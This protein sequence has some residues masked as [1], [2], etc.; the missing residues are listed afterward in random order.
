MYDIVIIGASFAGLTLAHH[1]PENLKVLI[2]EKKSRFDSGVEST[3]LITEATRQQFL[4]FCPIDNFIPNKIDTIGVV[5]PDYDKYFFSSTKKPWIY[6]TDTPKLLEH[7]ARTVPSNVTVE[8]NCQFKSSSIN[9][10]EPFTVNVKYTNSKEEKTCVARFLVGADGAR[11]TV[12]KANPALSQNKKFLAGLEKVFYGEI[13]FG[14]KPKSTVYHF[15]FGDFSLGYGGWL[16]P[17]IINGQA[18]FRV[19]LAK[20]DKDTKDLSRLN[21]FIKILVDKKIIAIKEPALSLYTFGSFIP[22]SGALKNLTADHTLLIGDAA[23][24][25]GAFAADGI[26]GAVISGKIAAELI[27]RYLNGETSA[28]EELKPRLEKDYKLLTYYRKQQFYRWL[29]NQMKRNRTYDAMYD[30]IAEEKEGFLAQFCDSKDSATSLLKVILK[31]KHLPKLIKYA[32]FIFLDM[33]K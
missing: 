32:W 10:R 23:G 19:G 2:I 27:P 28:L 33:L 9:P 30:V 5:S 12:A 8:L 11:S 6:S 13:N 15:W 16:S 14:P 18:A 17:T 21:D 7:L 24:L 25:C 29:W 3:G 20:L 1:L 26:K 22:I 31:V 4:S